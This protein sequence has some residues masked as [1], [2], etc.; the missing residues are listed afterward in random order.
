[1]AHPKFQNSKRR[2]QPTRRATGATT[3]NLALVIPIAQATEA[4]RSLFL[5]P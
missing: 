5:A 4:A 3:P 1:M 2:I